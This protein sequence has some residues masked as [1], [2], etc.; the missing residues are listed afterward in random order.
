M[1]VGFLLAACAAQP[2][3]APAPES[4]TAETT[5]AKLVPKYP[6]IRIASRTVPR[7]VRAVADV[8]YVRR[9]AHDL[10]LDLY[11]PVAGTTAPRPAIVFV[12]GGGWRTGVRANFAPMAI[13]MAERGYVAATI[14]YRLSPEAPYPAAIHDAKAAVRWVRA[15]AGEYGID[16]GR[17]AIAGGSAGGQIAALTGVT[18][19]EPH[20][21]PDGGPVSSDVQAIV[22][23]DGLS[24]FTSEEARKYEDDPA[25]QPSSAGAWFGGRYA[26]KAALWRDAS[27]LYHVKT[28]TPPILFIVSAQRRFSLGREEMAEKLRRLGVPNRV[29]PVPDT[30]HSFWLFDPWLAPTVE[31]TDG[32]L[33]EY[34]RPRL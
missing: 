34:L 22:N 3:Q 29:V 28:T 27:P 2:A 23:I 13:R 30:P 6:F 7:T 20:F 11:L 32:F 8:T 17:I 4:Y 16:P 31:A 1:G 19:G 18:N 12:H 9:G 10:K 25:K 5:Y 14:S 24:D 21:D 33:R 15:H 26:E